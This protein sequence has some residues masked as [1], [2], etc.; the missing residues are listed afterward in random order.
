MVYGNIKTI[1][2]VFFNNKIVATAPVSVSDSLSLVQ[3]KYN[4]N[5]LCS[6]SETNDVLNRLAT[7]IP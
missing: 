6:Q 2:G 1:F 3:L 7:S 5:S 4:L